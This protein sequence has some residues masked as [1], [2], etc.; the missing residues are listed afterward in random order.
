M[1]RYAV[2]AAFAVLLC[3]VTVLAADYKGKVKSVDTDKNT[4]T[5]TVTKKVDD[6]NVDEDKTFSFDKDK[7]K[8]TRDKNGMDVDV[9]NGMGNKMFTKDSLEKKDVTVAVTTEVKKVKVD[10]K[11]KDVE[12]A[13]TVKV[14]PK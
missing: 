1:I 13:T 12:F 8:V 2:S 9:K 5:I 11:E 10:D 3:T 14:N 7:V 4:I 6:K